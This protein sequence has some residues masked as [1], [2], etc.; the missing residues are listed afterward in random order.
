V[1]VKVDNS[2]DNRKSSRHI[3]RRL[4]SIMKMRNS[5]VITLDYIQFEKN[6][7]DSFTKRLSRNVID[8]A[9]KEMRLRPT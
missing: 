4:M 2:K 6:L 9:S 5:G 7:T 3:K 8:I 1:I